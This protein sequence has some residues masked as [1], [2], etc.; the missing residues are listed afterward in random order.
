MGIEKSIKNAALISGGLLPFR[1]NVPSQYKD[2]QKEYYSPETKTLIEKVARFSNDFIL[3]RVQTDIENDVW[4]SFYI[5]M[6][7]LVRPA[8]SITRKFDNYKA[9]IFADRSIQYIRPGTKIECMGSVW[10]CTNPMNVSGGDGAGIV[11]RCNATWNHLDYYGNVLKEPIIVE[12][13]RANA[14][15]SDS[16][17]SIYIS[18]GYFNVTCQYNKWTAQMDTNTRMILGKGAYRVTGY[19]DFMQEFTGDDDSRGILEYTIRY[20]E[21]NK[22]IDDLERHVAEGK[23]FTW[24]IAISGVTGEKIGQTTKFTASSVREGKKVVSTDDYPISYTWKSKDKTIA[25]VDQDG[26][27]TGV[28]EGRVEIVASLAQN[29]DIS[30]ELVIS[31]E[32]PGDET[33]VFFTSTFPEVLHPYDD[34]TVTASF[35]FDGEETQEAVSW[36]FSGAD[37][38]AYRVITGPNSATIYCYGYS[39]EKLLVTAKYGQHEAVRAIQLAAI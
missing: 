12:P 30:S 39:A 4:N 14:T 27:V 8:A 36:E 35:F 37:E 24:D 6:A 20:V 29:P 26:N 23:S 15:D 16:Q 7:D 2:K 22:A 18:K 13:Q 32:A 17:S 21:P 31:I 9:V 3:A 10:I 33:G 19:A 5:R 11:Q 1:S 25:T 34:A 28:G 38:N